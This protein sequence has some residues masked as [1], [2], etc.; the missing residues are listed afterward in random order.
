M[1]ILVVASHIAP[2]EGWG[3]EALQSIRGLRALGHDVRALV[4]RRSDADPCPQDA[5]LP[6]P[7]SLRVSVFSPLSVI[8]GI[9]AWIRTISAYKA[10]LA[11][12]RP[13]VIHVMTE[14]YA[15]PLPF[16]RMRSLPPVFL[17]ANGT[18]AVALLLHRPVRSLFLRAYRGAKGIFS[19][20]AYT[21][22]RLTA[23]LHE[24][25]PQNAA[26]IVKKIIPW[27]L[28]TPPVTSVPQRTASGTKNILF[29][30]ELK[31]RKGVREIIEAC[32]V[33]RAKH[34]VPFHLH[35]MGSAPENPYVSSLRVRVTELGLGD[36]VTFHGRVS[37][38]TLAEGYANADLFM[39]LSLSEPWNFEGYGLVFLEANALGV[40]VIGPLDS[41]CV[42]A[43]ADGRS[44]YLVPPRD[45][46]AAAEK[47]W[48][49]LGENAIDPDACR[50]WAAEHSV[51]RQARDLVWGYASMTSA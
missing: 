39:M 14:P 4:H 26:S 9:G 45:A 51:E 11:S 41:G 7:L 30:G 25:D 28:G 17:T 34:S 13:D 48:K 22:S 40:P 6:P 31:S 18:F 21:T 33:F 5:L 12:M 36:S 46:N 2:T 50:A 35:L 47:M 15:I 20:S 23:S 29:V 42:D 10:V 49:I 27:T 19:I 44:G 24:F 8:R 38:E 43:I 16:L 37:D 32:A 3:T 1:K